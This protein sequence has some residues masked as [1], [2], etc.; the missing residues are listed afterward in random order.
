MSLQES[1]LPN[2]RGLE[3]AHEYERIKGE[4]G[5]G[6]GLIWACGLTREDWR[7]L[8]EARRAARKA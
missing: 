1:N 2:R 6:A 7:A 8:M 3:L 4:D 5:A